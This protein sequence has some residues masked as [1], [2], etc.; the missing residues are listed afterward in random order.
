M[1]LSLIVILYSL[2]VLCL[3]F[4]EIPEKIYDFHCT[5]NP[6]TRKLV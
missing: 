3:P 6:S 4:V 5:S 2:K 1:I